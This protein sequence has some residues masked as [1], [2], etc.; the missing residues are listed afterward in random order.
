MTN[1]LLQVS[2]YKPGRRC[3]GNNSPTAQLYEMCCSSLYEL[4]LVSLFQPVVVHLTFRLSFKMQLGSLHTSL[5]EAVDLFPTNRD[6][7]SDYICGL[8]QFFIA[9][10]SLS[11]LLSE[12]IFCYLQ[13][14][15]RMSHDFFRCLFSV[16]LKNRPCPPEY[17]KFLVCI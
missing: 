10:S 7:H 1:F 6:H 15:Q 13:A 2:P 5:V 3:Y 12:L 11:T 9:F 16:A 8:E 14:L 17:L 4:P